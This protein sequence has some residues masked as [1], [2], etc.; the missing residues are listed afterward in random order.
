[1]PTIPSWFCVPVSSRSGPG[2][3]RGPSLGTSS[4]A[5]RSSLAVEHADVRPMELVGRARQEVAAPRPH[6]DELVGREVHG[7]DERQGL[8]LAGHGD[9]PRDVV[10]RSQ[11]IRRRTD[12]QQLHR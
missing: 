8:G 12:R 7:I 5:S 2:V 4:A 6:V 3:G 1:M 10:D 11:G 9:G